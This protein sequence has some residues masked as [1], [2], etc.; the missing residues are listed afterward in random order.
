MQIHVL[1]HAEAES[2]LET[3]AG[4]F[5]VLFVAAEPVPGVE[6][7]LQGRS[8]AMLRLYFHDA[9]N[10]W[11]DVNL[12]TAD[13]VTRALAWAQDRPQLI[14]TCAAGISRSSALAYLLWCRA[15]PPEEALL[16]LNQDRHMPN[17]LVVRLGAEALGNPAI[18]STFAEWREATL[19]LWLARA[20]RAASTIESV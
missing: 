18:F 6:E 3:S 5:D 1:S 7:A 17:E 12:P 20:R 13:H 15:L 9:V 2:F 10:P 16:Q 19:Q 4:E 11:P 14:V 8:R